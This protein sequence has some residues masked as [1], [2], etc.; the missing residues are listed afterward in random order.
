MEVVQVLAA[1][2]LP[3]AAMRGV[4]TIATRIIR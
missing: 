1:L 3:L 4:A 2:I